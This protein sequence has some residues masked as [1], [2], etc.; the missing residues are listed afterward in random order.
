MDPD[1][2]DYELIET[3]ITWIVAGEHSFPAR[4]SVLVR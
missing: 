3:V 1:K 2:L 4:G